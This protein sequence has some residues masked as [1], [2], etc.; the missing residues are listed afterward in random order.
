MHIFKT[1]GIA[2]KNYDL[3]EQD[4]IVIFY[5]QDYGI[6]KAVAKGA[7]RIKSRLAGL[8]QFPSFVDILIYRKKPFHLGII[9]DCN[10]RYLFPEIR[11]DILKFAYASYV[12]E[13][14]LFSLKEGEA[15]KDLFYLLLRALFLIEHKQRD[16]FE[17]LI[18]SFK[19]KLLYILGYGPQLRRCVECGKDRDSLKSFYF[20]PEK[21]GILCQSCQKKDVQAIGISKTTLVAME[22]LL[23]SRLSCSLKEDKRIVEK[24]ISNL[25]DVYFSIHINEKKGG[26]QNLIKKLEK[27]DQR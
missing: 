14:L 4:K 7:R 5:T 6:L 1:R 21:G 23:E 18:T 17:P 16:K 20:S 10:T 26:S 13:I 12:A 11:K 19:L 24:Q 15:N 3:S 27:I 22:Y 8:V 2:L 9:G 25:L